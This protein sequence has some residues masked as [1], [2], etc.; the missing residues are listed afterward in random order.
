MK[1][2]LAG[3]KGDNWILLY[4]FTMRFQWPQITNGILWNLHLCIFWWE[5]EKFLASVRVDSPL[6]CN[7]SHH[8]MSVTS[9]MLRFMLEI[10]VN[11]VIKRRLKKTHCKRNAKCLYNSSKWLISSLLLFFSLVFLYVVLIFFILR[12]FFS[13]QFS[14]SNW[15]ERE[16][17][18]AYTSNCWNCMNKKKKKIKIKRNI[19]INNRLAHGSLHF[20]KRYP[21]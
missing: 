21:T 10:I 2:P 9:W 18:H 5:M 3:M 4:D 12:Y 6:H 13:V 17:T 15:N 7:F 16:N 20:N 1:L 11:E 19:A 8:K 14:R